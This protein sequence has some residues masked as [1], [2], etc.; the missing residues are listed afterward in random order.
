MDIKFNKIEEAIEDIANGKIIVVVDDEDRENEGDLIMAAQLVTPE[1]INFMITHGKGLVCLPMNADVAKRLEL[2]QMVEKNSE[3]MK[4]AFTVSIDGSRDHGVTTGISAK[5]R[6]KTIQLAISSTSTPKD[7]VKPGHIFPLLAKDGGVLKRAGHTEAA[8]DLAKMAGLSEAGV[9]C[10]II[11]ENGEMARIPDLMTFCKKHDLKIVTIADLIKY[12]MHNDSFV[13]KVTQAKLP[14]KQGIFNI[15]GFQDSLS[16]QE[17]LAL[18]FGDFKKQDSV[19]V[20]VHSECLTGDTLGS[21]RCDCGPQLQSALDLIAKEGSGII[22]YMRQEGRGIGLLN[23]LK[24]YA[25]QD[26]GKDTVEANEDLGFEAD[27]RDY[28]VGAQMLANLGVSS[29]KL[30]T[31]NPRKVV[32]LEGYGINITKRVPLIIKSNQY[33]ELYLRTKEKKLGHFLVKEDK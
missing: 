31:N 10:E 5:D 15:V 3:V 32:G 14:L 24:A 9:I 22:L 20:R 19:L 12:K 2:D 6:A 11:K 17:H 7:I 16:G 29:I 33:N 13:K 26:K 21:L 23:K 27:L 1:S 18:T 8:V 28:G 30:I 4:T 25:L